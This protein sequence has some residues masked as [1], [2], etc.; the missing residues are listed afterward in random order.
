MSAALLTETFLSLQTV[1]TVNLLLIYAWEEKKTVSILCLFT[2]EVKEL[3]TDR[4]M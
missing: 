1:N 4:E 2:D 3:Q